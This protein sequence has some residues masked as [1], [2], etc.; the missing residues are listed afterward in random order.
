MFQMKAGGVLISLSY[1]QY[2][3]LTVK[4]A[5]K[6]NAGGFIIFVEA[7]GQDYGWVSCEVG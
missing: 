4:P 6:G 1:G 7:V 2:F 5:G 3:R